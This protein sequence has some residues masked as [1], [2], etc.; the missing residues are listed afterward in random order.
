MNFV[1]GQNGSGKS[2]VLTALTL[3]LGGKASTTSRGTNIRN[4]I[5]EKEQ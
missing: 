3:C 5:K 2:A 1:V 4:F